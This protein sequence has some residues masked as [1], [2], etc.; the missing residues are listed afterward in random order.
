MK[1]KKWVFKT[2]NL[3][4][5]YDS[6]YFRRAYKKLLPKWFGP[7]EIKEVFVTNGTYSLRN[8]DGTNYPDR[9]NHD[10]LKKTYVYLLD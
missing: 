1:V 4:M 6:R 5:M 10:K 7:Y 3:V 9:I 2:G 8:L